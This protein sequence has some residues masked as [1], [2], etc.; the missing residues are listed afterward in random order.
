MKEYR[1]G[2]EKT[3]DLGPGPA[4]LSADLEWV[5]QSGQSD[6]QLVAEALLHTY[7]APVYRL[8]L[9]LQNDPEPARELLDLIFANAVNQAYRYRPRTGIPIWFYHCLL[10]ALPRHIR[11]E[12]SA[13][14]PVL[15]YAFT[16]L[17]AE[18]LATL[19]DLK[20][21]RMKARL[22][23]LEKQPG[24]ALEKAGLSPEITAGL[25]A[26]AAWREVVLRHYPAPELDDEELEDLATQIIERAKLQGTVRRRWVLFQELALLLLAA[27]IV[28]LLISA[29][30]RLTPADEPERTPP[31]TLMVTRIVEK[32]VAPVVVV[33]HTATPGPT[34]YPTPSP[35]GLPLHLPA[36]SVD[37]SPI[38]ILERLRLAGM[39]W[40]TVWAETITVLY[41]P[42]GY[43]GPDRIQRSQFWLG[44]DQARIQSGPLE[45]P[46]EEIWVGNQGRLYAL[47]S[48]GSWSG[49]P[50]LVATG[51]LK[52]PAMGE[53][54]LIF[55]PLQPMVGESV[56]TPDPQIRIA[57]RDRIAGR[58]ALVIEWLDA[59]GARE[60][61]LW[62]DTQTSF[63]LRHQQFEP[64]GE[65]TPAIETIVTR[66]LFDL[67]FENQGLFDLEN[68]SVGDF[69]NDP[70]GR[71]GRGLPT[72]TARANWE[73]NP[74]PSYIDPPPGF[75][76][77]QSL[78]SFFYP[79]DFDLQSL[80]VPVDL[81]AEDYFL[82]TVTFGNPWWM[83]CERSPDGR[84]IVFSSR[85]LLSHQSSASLRWIDLLDMHV[86]T[87]RV[88]PGGN[89][90]DLAFAPDSLR[91]V[92]FGL[93]GNGQ[94]IYLADLKSGEVRQL[95]P[96]EQVRSLVWSPN[97]EQI[98]LIG[99]LPGQT[100]S[101][102]LIV[103][104]AGSG[105]MVYNAPYDAGGLLP[106]D[107]PLLG[108]GA[109]F[110]QAFPT[111]NAGLEACSAP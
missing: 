76:P 9:A 8:C 88:I 83:I 80:E 59:S 54:K 27:L 96:A 20:A 94:G 85:P 92:F 18:Q 67:D 17:S 66:I 107:A 103:L 56:K 33:I 62:L 73:S 41:G 39:F 91:L 61:R 25:Q 102:E 79:P 24:A 58:E 100:G 3:L 95:A 37:S 19:F 101:E 14:L 84:R 97:G 77:S 108:W 71:P 26:G 78:L 65:R 23:R 70:L 86:R 46:P 1:N 29:A 16:D 69:A 40:E 12:R 48:T 22:A 60:A 38:S 44:E 75:N 90:S 21:D 89:V 53:L 50:E 55:D 105:A 4:A 93:G 42:P 2:W 34:P 36:L 82:G 47:K 68:P 57:G 15:L 6:P 110:L 31:T 7:Y 87:R 49:Q 64:A 106:V 30:D 13:G 51:S 104:D 81:F 99:G 11:Q 10:Q 52:R 109:D 72:I 63:V 98:A 43:L 74:Q 28:G 5:L 111:S 45:G 35:V 32:V